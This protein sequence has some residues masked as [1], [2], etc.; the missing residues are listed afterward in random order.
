[1]TGYAL[2]Y[3]AF[4]AG[5]DSTFLYHAS[6]AGLYGVPRADLALFA[7]TGD[8]PEYVYEHIWRLAERAEVTPGAI[9]IHVAAFRGVPSLVELLKERIRTGGNTTSQPP[10]W[11]LEQTGMHQLALWDEGT[12]VATEGQL[13]RACT[14]DLKIRV[15]HRY[16][17]RLLG[18][19]AFVEGGPRVLCLIGIAADEPERI[20]PSREPWCDTIHPLV[21]A[22][23]KKTDEYRLAAQH[24]W[25][26]PGKSACRMC[27]YHGDDYWSWLR[28]EHPR[29]F[30]RAC[31]D[32]E[33]LRRFPRMRSDLFVHRSRKPLREVKFADAP[34]AFGNDCSGMCSS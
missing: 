22:G 1:M 13:P 18:V 16:L 19:R 34:A 14:R 20:T 21:D 31:L 2:T 23:V 7:D 17:R 24:G 8:E 33:A 12:P 9:P 3:I 10:L 29:D 15:S 32:D 26:L 25:R 11:T 6:E 28:R 30:E 5:D 27:P 4:G